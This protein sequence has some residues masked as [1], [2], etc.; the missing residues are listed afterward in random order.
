[1][2]HAQDL[3]LQLTWIYAG[4]EFCGKAGIGPPI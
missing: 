2:L 1:M 3:N 4:T